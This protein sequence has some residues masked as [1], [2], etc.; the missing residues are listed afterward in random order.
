[1]RV[2]KDGEQHEIDPLNVDETDE[3]DGDE[4]LK[5]VWCETHHRY[6]WHWVAR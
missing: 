6:E 5:L 3:I 4:Q 1:M 2:T